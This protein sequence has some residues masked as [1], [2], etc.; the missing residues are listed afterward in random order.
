MKNKFYSWQKLIL[1]KYFSVFVFS[2]ISNF[3]FADGSKDLYPSGVQG[4]R[5]H[6]RTTTATTVNWPFANNGIHYVYA[7]AGERITMASS[8]QNGGS[9][10]IRLYNPAGTQVVN[11]SNQGQISNRTAELAGPQLFGQSV[12]NRYT[13]LYY[14]VL[15]GGDGIY[16]V[17]FESR[18]TS[19]S[20]TTVLANNN[21][22]Q[23]NNSSI[24]AWDV[25]VINTANTAFIPGRVYTN[26]I[27]FNNGTNS[28]STNGFYGVL[29]ALTKDGYTYRVRNNGNN[30]MYFTFFVNNNGFI[31]TNGAPI[32]KS[33]SSS[34]PAF[35][36]GKV[37]NPNTADT[38]LQI[39]HKMFYRL[40]STDMPTTSVGAVPGG[41]TWLKSVVIVPTVTGVTVQG[42]EGTS[43]QIGNLK[44]GYIKF[45][46]DVQGNYSIL[47]QGA[48]FVT[49]TLTGASVAGM[50]NVYW[51][52]K[53]GAG[54]PATPSAI[55]LGMDVTVRLQ[56]AEVH[57]PFMDMEFN[58]TGFIL[59]LLNNNN[60]NQV[61]S[62]VI[63]WN[64][65]DVPNAA[66]GTT[67]N[68]KNNSHLPPINSLGISSTTNGH[69]WGNSAN[70]SSGTFGDVRAIDTWTFI[71]GE[72][73]TVLT[74]AQIRNADL[75][76]SALTRS[77]TTAFED[78]QFSYTV[79][80]K[81]AG[82]SDSPASPFTFTLPVGINPQSIV[83]AGG[84]CG[85]E[86]TA[87]TYDAI[88][89]RYNSV[90]N[91][92]NGCEITYTV[93]VIVT[94]QIV[95]GNQLTQAAIL[96][97]N[98]NSDPDATNPNI[99]VMPTNAQDE[100][101]NNGL[102]GNCNNILNN[103]IFIPLAC[104]QDPNL[105]NPAGNPVKHG[106]TLLK[107]AGASNG[108]WPMIRNSGHTALESNTKG[109]VVTRMTSDPSQT[110]AANHLN[111][112]TNPIDGMM[113]Y[114]TFS[115]CL[116]IFADNAWKCFSKPACP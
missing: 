99:L 49:R 89:H 52:G 18:G 53:D 45:S 83:F 115:K 73:T 105:T 59:E 70:S 87:A 13:P 36:A 17:E 107:K 27:N 28:P 39:T 64:D 7:K 2:I 80:V 23:G 57:F 34:N 12:V 24:M 37:H 94:G 96:R 3:L 43:Q 14:L 51:D 71:R 38:A 78:D 98:D 48:G 62:D 42:V 82:P 46:A 93:T 97:M 102:G 79:K 101:T 114:D 9:S 44:G 81:N 29:Y 72:E 41:S 108:N 22:T 69:R 19:D 4:V 26:V 109:L 68:P 20:N 6:L 15:P 75:S 54:V 35:L 11:N 1:N 76:I 67:P 50:N 21:W 103:T 66:N 106:V 95:S 25:S 85:T 10:A 104:Y 40:P 63:Y 113:V 100:C 30:G 60:L 84:G 56:G 32:Y 47:L 90:L 33:L 91:L 5:A 112:I 74:S 61:V 77:T 110:T 31:D 111:K 65:I 8:A 86:V 92:P 88:N 16:R 58:K 55:A 116:K